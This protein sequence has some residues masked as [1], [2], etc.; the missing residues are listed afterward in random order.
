[1][2]LRAVAALLAGLV[3]AGGCLPASSEPAESVT[4]G[5]GGTDEQRVLAALTVVALDRAGI[6]P[7]VVPDLGGTVVLRREARRGNVDLFWDYTGAAWT[8]GLGEQAPPANPVESYARV[9]SAD[10]ERGLTWLEP[11]EANATLAVFV[12]ADDLPSSSEPRSL[13]WLAGRL[14]R[15]EGTLCADPDFIERPGGLDTFAEA[16]AIDRGRLRVEPAGE[17][18]AIAGVAAGECFAGLATATS[19]AAWSTELVPLAD[20]LPAPLFPAFVVAPVVR[21]ETLA[22]VPDLAEALAPVAGALD[23]RTLGRLN[24]EVSDGADPEALAEEFLAD[25]VPPG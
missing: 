8:L 6:T 17:E 9:R 4:I 15:G 7:E 14:S 1:M 19:G 10:E 18:E 21:D 24:A 22:A 20:D 3:L 12:R 2:P 16:Y 23:T 5:V 25:V 13:T 11:T